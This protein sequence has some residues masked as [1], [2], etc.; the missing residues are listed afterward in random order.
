MPFTTGN[1][2][3]SLAFD[4]AE[5]DGL[6]GDDL[7]IL[8]EPTQYL[9]MPIVS[10]RFF[11][12]GDQFVRDC[13]FIDNSGPTPVYRS[14]WNYVRNVEHFDITAPLQLGG[15][16]ETGAGND[17]IRGSVNVDN[18]TPGGGTNIVFAYGGDDIIFLSAGNGV[19]RIN[20]GAGND[21][22]I[23]A[24][25][26]DLISGGP[27][28]DVLNVTLR[29]DTV[30]AS[31]DIAEFYENPRWTQIERV[32]IELTDGDDVLRATEIRGH[33][34]GGEGDDVLIF[35]R[36]GL[37]AVE[38]NASDTGLFFTMDRI[39][40]IGSAYDDR[41]FG[42]SLG[43]T[44]GGGAGNDTLF[45]AIHKD[46]KS[47]ADIF[48]GGSGNDVFV[49]VKADDTVA[50]GAGYDV[51]VVDFS[52]M[53]EGITLGRGEAPANFTG[54]EVYLGRMTN[55]DDTYYASF[56]PTV[57]PWGLDRQAEGIGGGGGYDRLFL[58]FSGLRSGW[59]G[60]FLS[61]DERGLGSAGAVAVD[62]VR[63]GA[64]FIGDW[65][66]IHFTG[67][68]HN[69][70]VVAGLG[71]DVI[72]GEGGN[73]SLDGGA[74]NNTLFGGNGDDH[75][76]ATP[77]GV[78]Q[79]YGG[80]GEDVFSIWRLGQTID[81]GRGQD[82]VE[83]D[84][85]HVS[86]TTGVDLTPQGFESGSWSRVEN[87]TGLLTSHDDT[88]RLGFLGTGDGTL[89]GGAGHDTLILD[90]SAAGK[91][92]SA[93]VSGTFFTIQ[94]ADGTTVDG[95]YADF[96]ALN[97]T[98]TEGGDFASAAGMQA[99]LIGLSGNDSLYGSDL[100]DLLDGGKGDDRLVG[101]FGND[102]VQGGSGDDTIIGGNEINFAYG[103]DH[104]TLRGGD[105][106]DI[107]LGLNG[108]DLIEAGDGDDGVAGG[109]GN[110]HIFGGLGSDLFYFEGD[111]ESGNDRIADYANG[112]D[113]IWISGGLTLRNVTI[114]DVGADKLVTWSAGS[115]LLQGMAGQ[116]V[117]LYFD[118]DFL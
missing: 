112:V 50:G 51:A 29:A 32:N 114:A 57:R 42:A 16:L 23:D 92:L 101:N 24:G 37:S 98:G 7:L 110:D 106:Q 17:T 93:S 103:G 74:G 118:A 87:V 3:V 52:E 86:F 82:T 15:M 25:L 71:D 56:L 39:R 6:A 78:M 99:R 54:I 104:D 89:S 58:D 55:Y 35:N 77:G 8:S 90:Y 105:G 5:I 44:L 66:E 4:N 26:N 108:H 33:L 107:I 61:L 97:F 117:N 85:A 115:V 46:A 1:D 111:L 60:A 47:G 21:I 70:T 10:F 40:F 79:A 31:I 19:D 68:R 75:L 45:G 81:G 41:V 36:T 48:Y 53:T 96:E 9:G 95:R 13:L 22:L 14:T 38:L 63:S 30:P 76:I 73:D 27:G 28:Y 65:E 109:F 84:F 91:A 100:D 11:K 49:F 80:A 69:D 102:L 113:E 116:T 20:A 62:P 43:D 88:A 94:M 12:F 72:R 34:F 67:S 59:Q 64:A 18:I 83:L 2:T